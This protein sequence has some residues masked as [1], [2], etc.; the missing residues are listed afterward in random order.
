MPPK[1]PIAPCPVRLHVASDAAP[2]AR[3]RDDRALVRVRH[4]IWTD[5]AAW[6]TLAP[7]ERYLA[8]VHAVALRR[9]DAVFC[10]E[11]AAALW[12]QPTFGEPRDIHL[13]DSR[14]TRSHRVGD[15]VRH[16]ALAPPRIVDADGFLLTAPADTAVALAR[17]LPPAWGVAAVDATIS[18]RQLGLCEIAELWNV[19][20]F[21]ADRRHRRRCV[22]A[23]DHADPRSES[24][25]ESVSR[26]VISWL[27]FEKP[28]LQ[29]PFHF[30]GHDDRCDFFW[31]RCGV[32]GES[33]GYGKYRTAADL[34]AEKRR[35]DRLRRH[36][37]GFARWDWNDAMRAD[38]L[39]RALEAS[40]VRRIHPPQ[41]AMLATLTHPA[42]AP[43]APRRA[44]AV[45]PVRRNLAREAG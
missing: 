42:P 35:E 8:R 28:E 23:L 29:H 30:E 25:G 16:A 13:F 32:V 5:A 9:P 22:W 44:P 37:R 3:P 27:G 39:R 15:V 31:P 4:G 18:G 24:V 10:R 34:V 40:G 43:G 45:P 12:G 38:P 19:L 1:V 36:L 41:P 7:W 17:A 33:D 21:Q 2:T 6:R 26:A 14:A 20:S 11:S